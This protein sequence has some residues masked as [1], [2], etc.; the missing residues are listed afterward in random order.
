[1]S[2][3]LH[4]ER[5]IIPQP[6]ESEQ[7]IADDYVLRRRLAAEALIPTIHERLQQRQHLHQRRQEELILR[8]AHWS[9][10][11]QV[12]KA[13][14]MVLISWR[15]ERTGLNPTFRGPF[16]VD[17]I[18]ANGNVIVRG[19]AAIGE[20]APT[21]SVKP[22]RLLPYHYNYQCVDPRDVAVEKEFIVAAQSIV[23]SGFGAGTDVPPQVQ[24]AYFFAEEVPRFLHHTAV[25][26]SVDVGH[27]HLDM[28]PTLPRVR[29]PIPCAHTTYVYTS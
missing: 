2:A 28:P 10:K 1:M 23:P 29:L 19:E 15:P 22:Q 3:D 7:C 12:Y 4:L 6:L 27:I 26:P 25:T 11:V 14:D 16:L 21:W 13:G 8:R 9:G 5:S 20:R 18:T 17:R 24:A